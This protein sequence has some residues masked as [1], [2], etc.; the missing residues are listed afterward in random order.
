MAP[1]E[2]EDKGE[3][4]VGLE[5]IIF[6]SDA[7][8]A[9]AITLLVID[10]RLPPNLADLSYDEISRQLGNAIQE[11]FNGEFRSFVISFMVLGNYWML[12]HRLFGFIKRYDPGLIW[13]NLFFLMSIAFLPFPTSVLGGY[14]DHA[15]A[16][17]LYAASGAVTGLLVTWLWN[18]ATSAYRL[19]DPDLDPRFIRYNLLRTSGATFVFLLSIPIAL[20]NWFIAELCWVALFPFLFLLRR[21]YGHA[22]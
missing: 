14:G 19:V 18:Y 12:H 15:E 4:G 2:V 13:R 20:F 9:I 8:F 22:S 1:I 3:G 16:V 17:I 11:V 7:V 5:R 21:R 10:L 6:F